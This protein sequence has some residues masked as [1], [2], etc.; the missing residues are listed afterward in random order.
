MWIAL[1]VC[2]G[3]ATRLGARKPPRR[4]VWFRIGYDG[5]T[6]H[7]LRR[8][9]L[10]STALPEK[11]GRPCS[12][13]LN[14]GRKGKVWTDILIINGESDGNKDQNVFFR[15]RRSR[16]CCCCGPSVIYSPLTDKIYNVFVYPHLSDS[17]FRGKRC[18][19]LPAPPGLP[20]VI[21]IWIS[22][23]PPCKA[24]P[25]APPPPLPRLPPEAN[26]IESR[27]L[28]KL[29][30]IRFKSTKD[31]F[32]QLL[33]LRYSLF[34]Y[35]HLECEWMNDWSCKWITVWFAQ[36]SLSRKRFVSLFRMKYSWNA[37]GNSP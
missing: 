37:R 30:L 22:F 12:D 24:H 32:I 11:P 15:P 21:S 36:K 20:H 6:P 14:F 33:F 31:A 18:S 26:S 10:T 25:C 7:D 19:Q 5:W 23:L 16:R 8:E 35:I 3:E 2:G 13:T 28:E 27:S 1:S 9:T 17:V 34:N 4:L 29:I